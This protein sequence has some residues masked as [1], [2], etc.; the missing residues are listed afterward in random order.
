MAREDGA[1]RPASLSGT[2]SRVP[3]GVIAEAHRLGMPNVWAVLLML[4]SYTG[5]DS[6][7]VWASC[8][9]SS[10]CERLGL[11]SGQVKSAI[12]FLKKKGIISVL[13]MGH[14]GHAGVYR[15]SGAGGAVGFDPESHPTEVGL[16]PE[17]YPMEVGS[18]SDS[19]PTGSPVAAKDRV[20]SGIPPYASVGSDPE[21]YPK[22]TSK[23]V[24]IE[25]SSD[26][27]RTRG[28]E[29]RAPVDYPPLPV[30]L[31]S[32]AAMEAVRSGVW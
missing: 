23:E 19:T 14:N 6:G 29:G 24:L 8:P 13:E 20:V 7:G 1:F 16:D 22:R 31:P 10:M 9:Q 26:G 18:E 21:S 2:Y 25:T 30:V 15:V 12:G 5:E 17:S 32:E 28:S 4:L 3:H 27:P 11:S